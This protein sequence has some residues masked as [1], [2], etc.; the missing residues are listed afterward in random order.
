MRASSPSE[1][2]LG[3]TPFAVLD[4]ETTGFHAAGA[5]RIVDVGIVRMAPDGRVEDEFV[6]LINPDR[7]VGPTDVHGVTASDVVH[8]PRFAQ[9]AG[10]IAVRL[11]GAVVAGHNLRFDLGF[12]TAEYARLGATFPQGPTVCTLQLAYQFLPEAPNR[13]LAGCCEALGVQLEDTH[14][15][16]GDA[17]A[18]A[19]LLLALVRRARSSGCECLDELG[20]AQTRLPGNSWVKWPPSG[21]AM[22]RADA[23]ERIASER[24][25]L[26]RLVQRLPA[27]GA[28]DADHAGYMMLLD[29]VLEDRL[30]IRAEADA[31]LGAASG[32][33]LSRED[34][35]ATHEGYLRNLVAAA[36]ADDEVTRAE[37]QDLETVTQLLGLPRAALDRLLSIPKQKRSPPSKR[38]SALKGKS[39]CFTGTLMS[40]IDGSP[41]TR[42]LAWRLAETAGLVIHDSVSKKLDILIVADPSSASGKARK[43][44]DY[45]TRIMAE[46]AFWSA[47]GVR[48]E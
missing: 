17:R 5:D 4:V 2:R 29:R 6:T 35:Q 36:Q 13:R 1:A 37:Q 40:S 25:Y 10:D 31:L 41:V 42:E 20:C 43:A 28:P 47:I 33:S 14:H 44:R 24:G 12:L 22:C 7:D 3:E 39:V 9:V 46:A 48:V 26:A 16:L 34:V 15:S 8:A 27:S 19:K 21:A 38:D 30:V 45:G 18:T 11:G 32:W 23:Q